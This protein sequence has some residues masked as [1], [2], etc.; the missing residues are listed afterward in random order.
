VTL[1]LDRPAAG[2]SPPPA[3]GVT[4]RLSWRFRLHRF[5]GR[6]APYVYVAPFFLV[7]AAFGLFPLV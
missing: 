1:Q 7:F 4:T 6:S 5:E 2:G 3:A